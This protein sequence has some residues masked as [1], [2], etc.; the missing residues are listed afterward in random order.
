VFGVGCGEATIDEKKAAPYVAE[1]SKTVED[2]LR[3]MAVAPAGKKVFKQRLQKAR[4]AQES[5]IQRDEPPYDVFVDDVY[6]SL[7]Y[8]FIFVEPAGLTERGEAV[9]KT[10]QAVDEH[11][12][13][14][15]DYPIAQIKTKLAELSKANEKFEKL[16][17][18]KTNGAE[19]DAALAWLTAQPVSAFALSAENYPKLTKTV[20]ESSSGERMKAR[21]AEYESVSAGMA[22]IEAQIEQLLARGVVRYAREMKHFRIRDVFIH[23]KNFDRWNN[24]NIE[25]RRPLKARAAWDAQSVWRQAGAITDAI[26]KANETEILYDRIRRTLKDVLSADAAATLASLAPSQ[27]QYAGLKKEYLRYRDIVNNGGWQKVPVDRGLRKGRSDATVEQLKKRLQIEGYYPADAPID[28]KFD[29]ALEAAI[30]AYQQTHQ[31]AVT[32]EPHR[33]FWGSLNIPAT[34]RMQQIALNM[35]RWRASNIRHSADQY[36]YVNIPDFTAEVWTDQKRAMRFGIV[37]GNDDVVVDEETKEKKHPNHTPVLSAYIDRVIYNPYWNVTD[38]I[39]ENEIL[40][41]VRASV[42]SAYQGKIRRLVSKKKAEARPNAGA[43][44]RNTP[45]ISTGGYNGATTVNAGNTGAMGNLAG[46]LGIGAIQVQ[47]T[48]PNPAKPTPTP[49]STVRPAESYWSIKTNEEGDKRLVFDVAGL[50]ELVGGGSNASASNPA[51]APANTDEDAPPS[52]LKSYFFYL[53]PATGIVDVSSTDEDH[54]P[55]WYAAN[56]YEVMF[57][58]HEVWEYVRMLP[59]EENSLGKVKVIFPNMHDVYLHDTPAKALFSRDIRAF[60]HGCMRMED[61]LGF[62]EYLLKQDGQWDDYNVAKILKD[63]LYEVIFFN[64]QIP[65]HIDYITVRVDDDGH[66]NFLADVYDKDHFGEEEA[67]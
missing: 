1:W 28:E 43:G 63:E 36:V 12:L 52:P 67:G 16:A 15:A 61:P 54:I 22:A 6:K 57:P 41:K 18:F 10:L 2:T 11:A 59:G 13:D 19:K 21:L 25:G 7:E 30:S 42:E 66:A 33:M 44:Q 23:P 3:E 64:R 27:P 45:L 32:G 35:E 31:M 51:T 58:G 4:A 46:T 55:V 47:R 9:W 40:P 14:P 8:Q 39:R 53:D 50:K 29:D 56:D 24:P 48:Q 37:V 62:A 60:S 38:R 5:R 26:S 49:A 17:S 65:V 20:L 34:R